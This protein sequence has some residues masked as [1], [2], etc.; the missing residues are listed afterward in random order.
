MAARKK[1]RKG[2]K[3]RKHKSR[4]GRKA[5]KTPKVTPAALANYRRKKAALKREMYAAARR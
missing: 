5:R 2:A 3:A 1:K 4:K